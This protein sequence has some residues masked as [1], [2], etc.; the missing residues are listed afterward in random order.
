MAWGILIGVA[1]TVL[2]VVLAMVFGKKDLTPISYIIIVVA[3]V[4]FSFEGIKYIHAVDDKKDAANKVNNMTAIAETAIAY[5]GSDVQNYRLGI[6][7]ATAVKAGLRFAY[8]DA[9]RY[10]ETS[11]LVGKTIYEC[12]EVLRESVVRSA[13]NRIW[14]TVFWMV[15]TL[16]AAILL[17]ILSVNIG[18]GSR[19]QKI[20]TISSDDSYTPSHC[21]DF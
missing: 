18:G 11:D 14:K 5:I 2:T 19:R 13:T 12:T 8:S 1:L 17:I 9:E 7:E 21:D 4:A 3:L 15:G 16:V 10:I 6:A 20:P